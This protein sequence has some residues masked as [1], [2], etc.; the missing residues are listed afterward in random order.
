MGYSKFLSVLGGLAVGA[1][2]FVGDTPRAVFV[3]AA[4]QASKAEQPRV[5][6]WGDSLPPGASR[7]STLRYRSE[8][9]INGG[10]IGFWPTAKRLSSGCR[11]ATDFS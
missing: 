2:L 4:P 9:P 11:E 3:D 1:G 7:C 6:L 5:D 10:S 8:E